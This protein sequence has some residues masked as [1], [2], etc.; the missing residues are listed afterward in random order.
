MHLQ[1]TTFVMSVLQV[2]INE[3]DK[4]IAKNILAKYGIDMSTGIRMFFKT[5]ARKGNPGF[6]LNNEDLT[7]NGFTQEFEEHIL[8]EHQNGE[9]AFSSDSREEDK[10]FFAKLMN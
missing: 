4:K 10:K 9:I 6:L 7:E 8:N 5:L 1:V 3:N 2:R